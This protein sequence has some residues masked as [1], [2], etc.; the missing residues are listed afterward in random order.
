M[1]IE[2]LKWFLCALLVF[3]TDYTLW[4]FYALLNCFLSL[5]W[6]PAFGAL[7]ISISYSNFINSSVVFFS[8]NI[9]IPHSLCLVTYLRQTRTYQEDPKSITIFAANF[10]LLHARICYI[11]GVSHLQNGVHSQIIS[12]RHNDH[13]VHAGEGR[14]R[15]SARHQAVT[16]TT[17]LGIRNL[18]KKIWF[19][20]IRTAV[21][22]P[23]SKAIGV[24]NIF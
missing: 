16:S 21:S 17:S 13:F 7:F 2:A 10:H 8:D 9:Y 3:F 1:L 11:L 5:I 20:D 22:A 24:Q 12:R 4:Q 19:V 6:S 14:L 18:K 23:D 15:C